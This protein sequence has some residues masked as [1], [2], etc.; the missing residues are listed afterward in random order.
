MFTPSAISGVFAGG[1]V[2]AVIWSMLFK[3]NKIASLLGLGNLIDQEAIIRWIDKNKTL[4]IIGTECI[5]FGVHGAGNTN[6]AAFVIGG[7]FFNICMVTM[8]IPVYRLHGRFRFGK[9]KRAW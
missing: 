9:Q 4:T 1:T 7:T 2:W 3:L 5:N 6:S 8:G